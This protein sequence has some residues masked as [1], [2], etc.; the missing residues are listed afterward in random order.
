MVYVVATGYCDGLEDVLLIFGDFAFFR[1]FRPTEITPQSFEFF[2][3]AGEKNSET[4]ENHPKIMVFHPFFW[5]HPP[6]QP[7]P[8]GYLETKISLLRNLL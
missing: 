2:F 8:R 4:I 5:S 6:P 3:T 7:R 1:T